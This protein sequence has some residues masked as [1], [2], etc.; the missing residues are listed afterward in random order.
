MVVDFPLFPFLMKTIAS[1][2]ALLTAVAIAADPT[3]NTATK[4]AP[5]VNSLGMKFVPVKISGGPTNAKLILFS[6]WDTR[7]QDYAEYAKAKGITPKKPDF[8]QDPTHPVVNVSWQ[9]AKAFCEWLTVTERTARKIR[10]QDEYRIPTDHEWSCAAGLG[11]RENVRSTPEKKNGQIREYPWGVQWLPPR[12]SGNFDPMRRTD[13]Y[14]FTSP[15]G[16]FPANANGLYDMGGNVSQWCEDQFYEKSLSRVLR[17]ASWKDYNEEYLRT[18][19]RMRSDPSDRLDI[20]GFRC[21]LQVS[22]N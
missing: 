12:G 6:I 7:V 22:I 20:V 14:E 8:K 17:G 18:S 16:S 1:L 9:D 21:V 3:P 2:L 13:D 11:R 4:D 19:T 15:V 10:D 5:F